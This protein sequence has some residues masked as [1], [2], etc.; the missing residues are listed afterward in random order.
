MLGQGV[1]LANIV[2]DSYDKNNS[3]SSLCYAL[4]CL[5]SGQMSGLSSFSFRNLHSADWTSQ[6][7]SIPGHL[8]CS[9]VKLYD[10]VDFVGNSRTL[11][12]NICSKGYR[13]M[14][15]SFTKADGRQ[16]SDNELRRV[17]NARLSTQENPKKLVPIDI[18]L[19]CQ[20]SAYPEKK[21][22][23]RG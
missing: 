15:R 20:C 13:S 1:G 11:E 17:V 14:P 21:V 12:F 19:I 5:D 18:R 23:S 4:G 8:N 10:G 3:K 7:P 22:A 2:Q 9:L 6:Y 16:K